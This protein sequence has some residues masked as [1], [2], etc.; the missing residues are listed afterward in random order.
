M[1][2]INEMESIGMGE[3]VCKVAKSA[4]KVAG[5]SV[6]A[7]GVVAISAVVASG[8]AAGSVVS[9]FKAAGKTMK[10]ILEKEEDACEA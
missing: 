7:V 2:I 1:E 8:V 5:A 9:G 6:A 3:K 10:D 4:L